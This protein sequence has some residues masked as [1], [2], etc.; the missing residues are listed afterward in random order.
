MGRRR[1][2]RE[3][4]FKALYRIDVTGRDVE[5]ALAGLEEGG[6]SDPEA[7]RFAR[8]L[9]ETVAEHGVSV[10]ETLNR[11]AD[12]FELS[13]MGVVDRTVLRLGASEILFWRSVPKEV[14]INEYVEIAKKFGSE[15]SGGLVNAILDRVSREA[16]LR[17]AES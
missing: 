2:G 7:T 12:R 11:A 10:D 5:D 13:R 1:L 17:R 9:L 15:D 14:S 8:E 3:T 6:P 4:A 16:E